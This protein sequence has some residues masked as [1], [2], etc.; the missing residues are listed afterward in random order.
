LPVAGGAPDLR[1]RVAIID[2]RPDPALKGH[3]Q[4]DAKLAPAIPAPAKAQP[5]SAQVGGSSNGRLAVRTAEKWRNS[6]VFGGFSYD[7]NSVDFP[8]K[9]QERVENV[10]SWRMTGGNGIASGKK[11][12]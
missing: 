11:H 6:G 12:S 10:V 1:A 3:A 4:R 9:T 8:N 2:S 7:G 5:I